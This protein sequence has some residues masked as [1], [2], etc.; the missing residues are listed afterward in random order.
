MCLTAAPLLAEALALPANAR[1]TREVVKSAASYSAPVA[2]YA[3]GLLP[4]FE[5]QGRITKQAYRIPQQGITPQQI[6]TPI[7][8]SLVAAGFDPLFK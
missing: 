8:E 1:L 2:P 5:V 6:L 3:A 4:V 7:E